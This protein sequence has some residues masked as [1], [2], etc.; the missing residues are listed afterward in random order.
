M[1]PAAL[2]GRTLYRPVGCQSCRMS[3]YKGRVGVFELMQMDS[4]LRDMTYAR[5]S[6][7]EIRA[8]ARTSGGMKSLREDGLRK[9]LEGVTSLE[10]VLAA[11]HDD[12]A[13]A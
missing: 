9:V 3:G 4:V 8:Q 12:S 7:Q 6:S 11:S 2:A 1:D 5:A 13:V 10:E